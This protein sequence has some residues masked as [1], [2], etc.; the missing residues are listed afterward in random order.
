ME[1]FPGDVLYLIS[2]GF[3]D[4]FGGKENKKFLTGRFQHLLLEIHHL[5]PDRQ[6]EELHRRLVEWMGNN[7]QVDD[8]LVIG[9]II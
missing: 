6:K 3:A 5:P 1:V 9:I 2:D 4:Q 8:I 7:A